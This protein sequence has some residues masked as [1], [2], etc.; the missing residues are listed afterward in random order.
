MVADQLIKGQPPK[1]FHEYTARMGVMSLDDAQF[2]WE[3]V[4][5]NAFILQKNFQLFYFI[6]FKV[7]F[8]KNK[9]LV[10]SHSDFGLMFN[11]TKVYGGPV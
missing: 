11:I 5:F 4:T 6:M 7:I 1:V 8:C 10:Y 2:Q 3:F 9:V